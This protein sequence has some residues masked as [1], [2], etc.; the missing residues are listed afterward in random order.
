M[1]YTFA[2]SKRRQQSLPSLPPQQDDK[3][4]NEDIAMEE[5]SSKFKSFTID[6]EEYLDGYM[7]RNY[8]KIYKS[9]LL[10]Y[11]TQGM[12]V[13]VCVCSCIHTISFCFIFISL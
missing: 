1:T 9:K 12:C 10:P 2:G 5:T 4:E 8:F 3:K 13:C 7:L 11:Q 6:L